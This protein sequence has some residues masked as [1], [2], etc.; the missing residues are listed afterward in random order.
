MSCNSTTDHSFF[1]Y[2]EVIEELFLIIWIHK[3]KIISDRRV[4]R[5][6]SLREPRPKRNQV[7]AWRVGGHNLVQRFVL[8]SSR[9]YQRWSTVIAHNL[10]LEVDGWRWEVKVQHGQRVSWYFLQL[11]N[12]R[13]RGSFGKCSRLAFPLVHRTSHRVPD[14]KR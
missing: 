2:W 13:G 7:S 8:H 9:F 4:T 10:A 11:R 6:E 3:F 14:W 12:L 5:F 1:G